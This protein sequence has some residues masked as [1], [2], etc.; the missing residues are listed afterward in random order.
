M[1]EMKCVVLSSSSLLPLTIQLFLQR[2]VLGPYGIPFSLEQPAFLYN[3]LRILFSPPPPNGQIGEG[4]RLSFFNMLVQAVVFCT[5]YEDHYLLLT[6]QLMVV[7]S[8][9]R[10]PCNGRQLCFQLSKSHLS[11]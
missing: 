11:L 7:V 9:P 2:G 3:M 1:F 4:T 5:Q 8:L 6:A 10:L